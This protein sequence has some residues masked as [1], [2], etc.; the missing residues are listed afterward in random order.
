MIP[1]TCVQCGE[2][3]EIGEDFAG[4][5]EFCPACGTLNDIPDSELSEAPEPATT[6]IFSAVVVDTPPRSGIP[7]GL[8]WTILIGAIGL[9]LIACIMLFS[10][11]W[12]SRNVQALSDATNRGDVLMADEDYAGAI[13]QYR[14]VIDTVG[15]RSIES[16]F[17]L[18]LIER[19]REG[20][21]E[22][23][24]H[25]HSPPP[26]AAQPQPAAATQ[27][28][29]DVHLALES[30]QRD[31]EAFGPFVRDHPVLF[32]DKKGNWR[33]RQYFVWQAAYDPPS[34]SG[35]P[36]ILL[37]YNCS[38]NITEGHP[39]RQ[40]AAAD[41]HF[42]EDESPKELHFQTQFE[43]SSGK[44][45]ILHHEA[46]PEPDASPSVNI[47]PSLDDFYDIERDAFQAAPIP[48]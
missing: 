29:I 37:R 47:R 7:A 42:F 46:D 43:W 26:S 13:G 35:Q 15:H 22:A 48:A 19:A 30:F 38:S 32:Q 11:N 44:W 24:N 8:W 4:A 3:F 9:F 23:N 12:E 10:D 33:R 34:Q 27:P 45:F 6:E 17:I 36:K 5:T 1:V 2:I 25:L 31:Y 40:D 18:H 28:N 21:V 20:E 41:D 16:A 14:Q 39:D